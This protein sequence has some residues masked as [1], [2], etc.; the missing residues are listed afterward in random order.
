MYQTETAIMTQRTFPFPTW[1]R[2]SRAEATNYLITTLII[3]GFDSNNELVIDGDPGPFLERV[4]GELHI[5]WEKESTRPQNERGVPG[6]K[7]FANREIIEIAKQIGYQ[8]N[9]VLG[10]AQYLRSF[11]ETAP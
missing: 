9:T 3:N 1:Q 4:A 11:Q 8:G 7:I 10:I 6:W 5:D 2:L